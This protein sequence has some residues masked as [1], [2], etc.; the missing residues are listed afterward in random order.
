MAM[1]TANVV[2]IDDGRMSPEMQVILSSS[3]L[4]RY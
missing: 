2:A 3:D 1:G 4:S